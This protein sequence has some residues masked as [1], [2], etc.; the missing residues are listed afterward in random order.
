MSNA[1]V[2][3]VDFNAYY[4]TYGIITL[5]CILL[6]LWY[7]IKSSMGLD[8]QDQRPLVNTHWNYEGMISKRK[9]DYVNHIEGNYPELV[10]DNSLSGADQLQAALVKKVP[11]EF[12]DD[13]TDYDGF[14]QKGEYGGVPIY[15]MT[16]Y[17]DKRSR[18]WK[19]PYRR[20]LAVINSKTWWQDVD[21]TYLS[22]AWDEQEAV[23]IKN[24]R[25]KAV[26]LVE[27]HPR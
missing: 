7:F 15:I 14:L 26:N 1:E 6:L 17:D 21:H 23:K 10:V 8:Y 19:R 9:P 20:G 13:K 18:Q 12:T 2:Y 4:M 25:E 16:P 27:R 5:M 11:Y 22:D 24:N 3:L